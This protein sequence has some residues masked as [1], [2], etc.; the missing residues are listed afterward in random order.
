MEPAHIPTRCRRRPAVLGPVLLLGLLTAAAPHA[1]PRPRAPRGVSTHPAPSR[2]ARR[3]P[4]LPR[5]VLL[6][7]LP[8][9]A[10]LPLRGRVGPHT[11]PQ[12]RWPAP[13]R[14]QRWLRV[15]LSYHRGALRQ[16]SITAL[17]TP[18]PRTH[19]R[20]AGRFLARVFAARRLLDVIPFNFPLLA[21]VES[22]TASGRRIERRMEANLRTTAQILI[23]FPTAADRVLIEDI[24]DGSRWRLD[25]GTLRPRRATRRPRRPSPPPRRRTRVRRP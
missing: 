1:K 22:F 15:R 23:P 12:E 20:V 14:T 3:S 8:K 9:R 19:R 11:R 6:V 2:R 25:L 24:A 5:A 7:A 18:K 13:V 16:R 4:P 17:R 21:P 10:R